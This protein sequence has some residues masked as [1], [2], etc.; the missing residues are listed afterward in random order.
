MTRK[1]YL[2]GGAYSECP[3]AGVV[4]DIAAWKAFL[5]SAIGG[6]W[7]PEEIK[8]LSGWSREDLLDFW[9][10]IV[11]PDYSLICFS[12]HGFVARDDLGFDVTYLRLND[13]EVVAENELFPKSERGLMILDCCRMSRE[14]GEWRMPLVESEDSLDSEACRTVFDRSVMSCERGLSMIYAVDV[15]QQAQDVPSFTRIMLDLVSRMAP[16]AMTAVVRANEAVRT[17]R[18]NAYFQE[19]PIYEGGRRRGHFP[20]AVNPHMAHLLVEG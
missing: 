6:G 20:L 14:L 16:T 13:G 1:A 15:N 19:T 11:A 18:E 8:D 2:I 5:G 17:I 9:R 3:I 12:G 7:E 4:T 10:S